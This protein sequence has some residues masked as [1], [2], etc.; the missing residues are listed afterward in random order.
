MNTSQPGNHALAMRISA[1]YGEKKGLGAV[2]LC[3]VM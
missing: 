3:F 2:R 1:I